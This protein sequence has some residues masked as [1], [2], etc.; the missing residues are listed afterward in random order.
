ME[1]P[2]PTSSSPLLGLLWALHCVCDYLKLSLSL[3]Y[4]HTKYLPFSLQVPQGGRCFVLSSL[5]FNA[6]CIV[7]SSTLP[8]EC[9]YVPVLY[10]CVQGH[11]CEAEVTLVVIPG[12]LS[13]LFV[14]LLTYSFIYLITYSLI[15]LFEIGSFSRTWLASH[16]Q[17]PTGF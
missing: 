11:V 17:G 9:M 8:F 15:Y 14:Y 10:M 2:L 1:L 6:G 16:H 3:A 7:G 5:A 13:T 12:E 4:L